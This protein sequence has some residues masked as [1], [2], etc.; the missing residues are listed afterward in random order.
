MHV[1]EAGW[2]SVERT[3]TLLRVLADAGV[4]DAGGYGLVVLVEGAVNGRAD[5]ST[6]IATRIV[7]PQVMRGVPGE[8]VVDAEESEF[9]YCVSF[10]VSGAGLDQA[11]LEEAA[12]RLGD[13]LLVVGDRAQLKVHVHTDEPG[14]VLK[15]G[16][17]LGA[18]SEI[19]IDNMKIQ[20]AARSDRPGPGRGGRTR[21]RRPHSG[22]G[23]GGWGGQ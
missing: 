13:S 2:K 3:P 17:A 4:V 16:T 23:C 1:V 8:K 15:V 14:D 5:G 20:T 9:T 19:E 22:G 12:G 11:F 18:L 7:A 10:L 6:P 21:G